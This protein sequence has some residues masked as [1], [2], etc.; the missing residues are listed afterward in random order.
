MHGSKDWD[1]HTVKKEAVTTVRGDTEKLVVV[2]EK[3]EKK[4]ALREI[5]S[6]GGVRRNKEPTE[7]LSL[8]NR[9]GWEGRLRKMK[10]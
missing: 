3:K 5:V 8:L 9:M 4:C 6:T 1:T 2:V 7:R 10:P